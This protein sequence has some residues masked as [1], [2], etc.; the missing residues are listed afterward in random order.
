MNND[1]DKG[2]SIKDAHNL[3]RKM[4]L[5]LV[6]CSSPEG[7]LYELYDFEWCMYY[8]TDVSRMLKFLLEKKRQRYG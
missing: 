5:R 4:G 2:A 7:K 1:D 6:S 8:T 3:A